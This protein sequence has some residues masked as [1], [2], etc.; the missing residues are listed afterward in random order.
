MVGAGNGTD[1]TAFID[2]V[3]LNAAS[4]P[5][6]SNSGFETPNLAGAYQYSPSGATWIFTVGAGITGNGNAFTSGNGV[7]PEGSQVA[8]LQGNGMVAQTANL[9]AGSYTLSFQA[10]QRGNYQVGTQIVLVQLDGITVGQYQPPG[11]AYSGYT[12]PAFMV[13]SSGSHT[14]S[15]VGAGSGSDFTAFVDDVRLQ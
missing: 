15:L 4:T 1:F 11:T 14:I 10:A 3:R 2:D 12:T 9:T 7:A 5:A 8:F 13:A 6:F